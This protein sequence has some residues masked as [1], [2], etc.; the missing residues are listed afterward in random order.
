MGNQKVTLGEHDVK[1][2]TESKLTKD[3]EIAS[4]VNHPD[5]VKKQ[6][7]ISL[8]KVKGVID[9]S[10]YTPICLP[11][12]GILI[13]LHILPFVFLKQVYAFS[14]IFHKKVSFM[15]VHINLRDRLL[16]PQVL[17]FVV[18][19]NRFRPPPSPLQISLC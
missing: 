18:Q 17:L 11:K 1:S 4:V 16:I 12:A 8:I 5:I 6:V 14:F 15:A 19:E 9:I 2:K 7:D 13:F 3:F 10:T